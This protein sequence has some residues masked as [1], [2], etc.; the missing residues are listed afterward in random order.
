MG[1]V[2]V[3]ITDHVATAVIDRPPVNAITPELNAEIRQVFQTL[4]DSQDVHVAI[5]TA[6]G[7]RAF[8]AGADLEAIAALGTLTPEV[9]Q[10]LCNGVR[11]ALWSIYACPVPVIAA[12]N[13]PA[14]G[15]G[16][17]LAAVCD[18]IIAAETATFSVPEIDVGLVGAGAELSLLVPRHKVRELFFTGGSVSAEELYRYGAVSAVVRSEDL[19]PAANRLAASLA[20]KDPRT[21]RFAKEALNQTE[22]LSLDDAVRVESQYI[23]RLLARPP[24]E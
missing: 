11:E 23:L 9:V 1:Y 4:S 10:D 13:G 20:G 2:T 19:L 22:F 8:M 12:V 15:G 14:V 18:I 3:S 24:S 5:L 17:A 7:D 21:L 16:L 6:Q